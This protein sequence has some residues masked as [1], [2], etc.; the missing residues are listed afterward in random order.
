MVRSYPQFFENVQQIVLKLH[1]EAFFLQQSPGLDWAIVTT[2]IL[3]DSRQKTYMQQKQALKTH[4]Q[5]YQATEGR[6]RRRNMID[7]LYDLVVI[8]LVHGVN[9][10]SETV[11]L[12]ESKVGRQNLAFINYGENGIRISDIG[13]RQTH[14]QLGVCPNW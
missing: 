14:P 2:E 11:D 12:T 1:T 10:L 7:A 3:N 4:A 5:R 9:M 6:V 8:K 13:R